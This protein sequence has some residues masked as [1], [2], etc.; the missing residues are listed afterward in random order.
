MEMTEI[1]HATILAAEIESIDVPA[2]E[3]SHSLLAMLQAHVE[4]E[5]PAALYPDGAQSGPLPGSLELAEGTR[6]AKSYSTKAHSLRM[7]EIY[8][9][10]GQLLELLHE[11]VAG[12]QTQ[13]LPK[14]SAGS[15]EDI[16]QLI[17][18]SEDRHFSTIEATLMQWQSER[19]SQEA[20]RILQMES[21]HVQ[22]QI[23]VNRLLRVMWLGTG[24]AATG[25][26][27][28]LFL[29]SN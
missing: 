6:P 9:A 24:L 15:L 19:K 25:A 20:D 14:P 18:A 23:E 28:A 2:S 17:Q 27:L 21:L 22:S 8:L 1:T 7:A 29:L 12:N 3:M 4:P 26:G 16:Q 11:R 13:Q 5:S 10:I